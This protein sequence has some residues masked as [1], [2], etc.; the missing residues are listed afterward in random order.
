MNGL[1]EAT[2]LGAP[3]KVISEREVITTVQ[4]A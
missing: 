2:S 1:L 3:F 4:L